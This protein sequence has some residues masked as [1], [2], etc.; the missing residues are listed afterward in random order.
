MHTGQCVFIHS[1][2]EV[3]EFSSFLTRIG[4]ILG[5]EELP[6]KCSQ[7]DTNSSVV[8]NELPRY[9]SPILSRDF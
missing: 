5:W 2:N 4:Q 3:D 6:E 1:T 7:W 8:H 9:H